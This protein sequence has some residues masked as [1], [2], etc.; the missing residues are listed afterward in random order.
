[1][2]NILTR[3]LGWLTGG[4]GSIKGNRSGRSARVSAKYE[5]AQTTDENKNHWAHADGDSANAANKPW[6][7]KQIRERARYERDNNPVANGL[8]NTIV[9]SLR[10]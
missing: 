8:I 6:V 4:N 7:R 9:S 10:A 3:A 1:M 5:A 2:S